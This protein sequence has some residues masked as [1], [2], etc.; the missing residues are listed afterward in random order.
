[1]KPEIKDYYRE[2]TREAE[3]NAAKAPTPAD[4]ENWEKIASGYRILTGE[5]RQPAP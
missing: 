1:M 2:K 5:K 3:Q 4:R